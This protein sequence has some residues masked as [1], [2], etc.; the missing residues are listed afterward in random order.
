MN[1]RYD[2]QGS[3][4]NPFSSAVLMCILVL[5]VSLLGALGLHETAVGQGLC[6]GVAFLSTL[7]LGVALIRYFAYQRSIKHE[8]NQD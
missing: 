8:R 5:A 2:D 4:P 7:L 6:L 1:S 3:E